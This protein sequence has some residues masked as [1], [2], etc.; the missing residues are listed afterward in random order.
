MEPVNALV[1]PLQ[2]SS[3]TQQCS[4]ELRRRKGAGAALRVW[5][6]QALRRGS[7]VQH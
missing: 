2:E 5:L 3:S 6:A 7:C 1:C 4:E